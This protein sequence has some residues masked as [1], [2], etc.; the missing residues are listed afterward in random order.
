MREALGVIPARYGAQRFP[1]KPLAPILGRPML[2]W[3]Y[4][5]ARRATRLERLVVATDDERILQA[6]RGFGAEACMTSPG[7]TSGTERV[8]ELAARYDIPIVINIQGDEPLIKGE[9]IDALVEALQDESVPMATLARR[10]ANLSRI[11][12]PNVV[13]LVRDSKGFALYFSRSPLPH[14][15]QEYFWE[16]IG[17]YGY[18]KDFLLRFGGLPASGL[19][20]A[21]KLE[22]LRA[23]EHGF[24]IQVLESPHSSLSVDT[25]EDII[26]A[27]ERLRDEPNYDDH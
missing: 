4:E 20:K 22:Q 21:E 24:R 14:S 5:G 10:E 27:E 8:A 6:A 19:E 18:Q 15:A 25:P 12:D 7:H 16:H 23:L 11:A 26:R 3:V 2:Q 1:G 9:A 17:I 13:K